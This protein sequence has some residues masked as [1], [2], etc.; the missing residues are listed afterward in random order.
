MER[1]DNCTIDIKAE[2]KK[3][4]TVKE[5]MAPD[6]LIKQ[7]LKAAIEGMLE[8]EME[9]HLGYSKHDPVGRNKNN[10]RNG[11]TSK[12]VRTDVGEVD[13]EIPRD[14][15]SSFQPQ[16][17]KK[18][19][20]NI[21]DLDEQIIA[22][23]SKGM[24]TRDIQSTMY[25]IYGADISPTLVSAITDKVMNIAIEWQ[26]RPLDPI[27][28]IVFFDAIHYRV[29]QNGKVVSKAA[30]TAI[31]VTEG[32]K[33]DI[34]GIWVGE[35]EAAHFWL[36][37]FTELKNRGVQDILI[38]CIDG[39]T[40]V[41]DAIRSVFPKTEVQLCIVH[42]IRNSMQHVACSQR[43]EFLRDLKLVYTA[44]S[45]QEALI[46]LDKLNDKWGK[47][48]L[49][50]V[51]PW[52]THW[53]NLS[54]FLKYP[55]EMRKIIYTTN[56]IENLNRRFRKVTKNRSMFSHDQSLFKMLFLAARDV[57][58]KNEHVKNWPVIKNL[59]YQHFS[60]RLT[61]PI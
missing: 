52:F 61:M 28:Y 43:K 10:S 5:L 24:T 17:V 2:A 32:G 57:L 21:S 49:L 55:Q 37:I 50:A 60:E 14:R 20:R 46:E 30:Y 41:P 25:E 4:K 54:G 38:T 42:M 40:G 34:L 11:K 19:E 36:G 29:R 35:H 12:T 7:L 33:R 3:Y 15:E 9:A 6:G 31:G 59:F 53:D 27:Y 26:N 1:K 23:Y 18:H 48:Y 47:R 58:K 39:I 8:T 22:M 56:V 16:V 13:L 44:I 45:E 51:K